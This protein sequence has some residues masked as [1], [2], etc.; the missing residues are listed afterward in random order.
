[1]S[2]KVILDS[3]P[4]RWKAILQPGTPRGVALEYRQIAACD[5]DASNRTNT[6]RG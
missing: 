3:V 2:S 5:M 6:A 1:M 4:D